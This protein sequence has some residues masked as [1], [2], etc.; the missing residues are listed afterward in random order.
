M[1]QAK[2]SHTG[3]TGWGSGEGE[4]PAPWPELRVED[5]RRL[6]R[7]YELPASVWLDDAQGAPVLCS[8]SRYEGGT[9]H[10]YPPT[11][12]SAL[13]EFATLANQPEAEFPRAVLGFAK[14]WGPMELCSH[15]LPR[16]HPPLSP[17]PPPVA[18]EGRVR[19]EEPVQPWQKFSR[20]AAA[21][22][23]ILSDLTEGTGLGT[24][25][26]WWNAAW[27]RPPWEAA[28][29]ERWRESSLW[30]RPSGHGWESW[31]ARVPES[32]PEA[33][34]GLSLCVMNWVA[35]SGVGLELGPR[36]SFQEGRPRWDISLALRSLPS[37]LAA[38]LVALLVSGRGAFRCAGCGRAYTVPFD[39]RHRRPSI[40][41]AHEHYCPGCGKAASKRRWERQ[42]VAERSRAR[43]QARRAAVKARAAETSSSRERSPDR[44]VP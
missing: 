25:E 28:F 39:G 37:R 18:I 11:T 32:L 36:E 35:V 31:P 42:H 40:G 13:S 14:R 1:T 26:A 16:Q 17:H 44:R 41:S 23:S 2:G 8:G 20:S 7:S 21:T 24:P 33:A 22:L 6:G 4:A 19:F 15:D 27:A 38:E 10:L 12:E 30:L 5:P 9:P 3:Q 34:S 29:E 43:R